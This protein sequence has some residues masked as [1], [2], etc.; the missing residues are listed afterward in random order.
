M[1]DAALTIALCEMLGEV[2]GWHWST[3]PGT[4][5]GMVGVFYGD[6]P[7]TPDRAIGVRVYGGT[8]DPLVYQPVRDVQLR[9]RG[10][11]DDLDDADRIAGFA[12]ALLQGR[13]RVRGISW[14]QRGTFGPLGAD[15]NG[16][17]ERSENYRLFLDN[18]EVGT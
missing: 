4:P 13:S 2:P 18:P 7:D 10:A 12:F 17:E 16:R 11:R 15:T 9:I 14:I 6:I 3:A 8:D 5:A 1:D